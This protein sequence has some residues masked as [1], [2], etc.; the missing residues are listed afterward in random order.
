GRIFL[1]WGDKMEEVFEMLL[2]ARKHAPYRSDVHKLLGDA[3]YVVEDFEKA[4]VSYRE[5][6]RLGGTDPL[7][8]ERIGEEISPELVTN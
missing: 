6:I 7:A 1:R 2:E 4:K 8:R 3:Y 5:H